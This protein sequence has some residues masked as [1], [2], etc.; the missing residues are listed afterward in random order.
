[1]IRLALRML[2]GDRAKYFGILMGLTFA[3][4]L[5][6]QQGAIFIGLMTRTFSFISDTPQGDLWVMDP[7]MEHHA[8]SK[9]MLDT[10]LQR[11]RSV[12]G[13][14]WAVPM[15]KAFAT[16]RL[17]SGALRGCILVGVD[18]AT[19]IG[20][21]GTFVEG[22]AADLRRDGAMA[23]DIATVSDKLGVREDD[24]TKR[25]LKLGDVLELNDHRGVVTATYKSRPNFF[26]EPTLY[27]TFTRA[28]EFSPN[29]RRKLT[30]VMVKVKPGADVAAVQRDIVAQ[31]GMACR[32]NDEFAW[33][34]A[35]YILTQTGI[36]INFG[37]AVLLGFIV[38][39]AI[40]GQTFF[41]FVNDNLRF[42]AALKAMGTSDA[43]LAGMV[44][45]QALAAGACG[46]G[47]GVGL[48]ALFGQGAGESLAFS[49]PWQLLVA[50]AV[51]IAAI[52][53]GAA[54]LS[55]HRLRRLEPG[56]V[57]KA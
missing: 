55:I 33:Q 4:L 11:V 51:A 8:D 32:T 5:M 16:L 9:K 39:A 47:L 23:V 42:F 12:Q 17:P 21:P 38:G 48:A 24:G 34:T 43:R 50:S 35:K 1:M 15:F 28:K 46:Y 6:T 31:T 19:L 49:M 30:F 52:S 27:T 22:S 57:F 13:V 45:A 10:Q 7:E 20:A 26:W 3:S 56:V 14:E 54:L 44:V 29:E 37:I 36:A 53:V 40:A 18:D 41:N 25:A 2:V